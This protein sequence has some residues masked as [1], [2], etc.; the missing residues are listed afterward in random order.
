MEDPPK[1]LWARFKQ[2]NF[3]AS[4]VIFS[5]DELF[6]LFQIYQWTLIN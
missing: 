4:K 3:Y 1:S 6:L 5:S 2:S